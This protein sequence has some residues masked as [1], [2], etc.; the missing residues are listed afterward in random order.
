MI[1]LR[2][3]LL[4]TVLISPFNSLRAER[5]FSSIKV[6]EGRQHVGYLRIDKKE[7]MISQSTVIYIKNAL[8]HYKK[9]KPAFI[10][11][12]LNTPGGEVFA[13]SE[14]A[15]ALR[16]IDSQYGIPVVAYINNWAISA[17]ALIAYSCRY[18]VAA[19]DANMGAA[20]PVMAGPSGEMKAASE[21]INSALRSD[22]ANAASYYGRN[23]DLAEAMVD[24][25]ILLVLR[26]D[27]IL[28]L[29]SSQSPQLK[30]SNRDEVIVDRGK[31]LS[32]N[33][34]QLKRYGVADLLLEPKALPPLSAEERASGNYSS[35]KHP[36]FQE[37]FFAKLPELSI[38]EYHP[39]FRVQ[40]L[41]FL[42]HPAVSSLLFMGL[43][44]GFYMELSTPG[45]GLPGLVAL[46]SLFFIALASFSMEAMAWLD[47][48]LFLAGASLV[49][50]ELLFMVGGGALGL[51]G[52][53]L[54]LFGLILMLLPE[55]SA[56]EIVTEPVRWELIGES[57]LD[58]LAWISGSFIASLFV[59]VFLAR[60]ITPKL[61][62]KS[63]LVLDSEQDKSKGYEAVDRKKLPQVGST[64]KA[65]SFL[66]PAGKIEIKGEIYDALTTHDFIEKGQEVTVVSLDGGSVW[67]E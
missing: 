45:L 9:L 18:I 17:G 7:D 15:S 29:E 59:M 33:A 63:F 36:I 46:L 20:Q 40:F 31:L 1:Y 12:E 34:E 11:L 24:S 39:D 60:Y 2:L 13:A 58:R 56:V 37:D 57:L 65:R 25:D 55:I 62:A 4:L 14:I 19:K 53:V 22:F 48:V 64:G 51:V 26:N 32:L 42:N 52:A 50:V 16:E 38:S 3:F 67:V 43:M 23:P 66:R 8:E 27:Q 61:L 35:K 6:G 5:D 54:A 21:K 44:I 10:I 28:S 47:L 41:A 49:V 30:S